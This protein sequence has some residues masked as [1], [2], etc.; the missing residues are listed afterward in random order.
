MARFSGIYQKIVA[1]G[2]TAVTVGTVNVT[3]NRPFFL[4]GKSPGAL[5]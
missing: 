4:Y 1:T 5:P 2:T 3:V